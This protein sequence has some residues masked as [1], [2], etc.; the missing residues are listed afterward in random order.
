[1]AKDIA[2]CQYTFTTPAVMAHPNL[3][4]PKAFEKNGKAQGE[5][6]YSAVFAFDANCEEVKAIKRKA[7]EVARLEWPSVDLK[8]VVFPWQSG[9]VAADKRDEKC[10]QIGRE[11][12]GQWMRGKV[13]LKASSRF[14]VVL[15]GF[16]NGRIVTY[17]DEAKLKSVEGKFF[18]GAEVLAQITFNAF[19]S[20]L[21]GS[22]PAINTYLNQV[23]VTGKGTKIAG[24]RKSAAQV[25]SGY[26]GAVSE[27]NP[28]GNVEDE[29]GAL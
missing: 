15:A 29:I 24:S 9:D 8:T 11:P 14:P 21:P 13:L 23:L 1:M 27:V 22:L 10:R 2:V 25:F 26:A 6:K 19:Q 4:K 20:S 7:A 3:L 12:D 28:M 5:P 16:E 18:F 17:E